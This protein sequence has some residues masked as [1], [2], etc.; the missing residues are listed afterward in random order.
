MKLFKSIWKDSNPL[1]HDFEEP[2]WLG[3]PH[4]ADQIDGDS[5]EGDE[6]GHADDQRVDVEG[7]EHQEQDDQDEQ[8][9]DAEAHLRNNDKI[10][11][12][13]VS[14]CIG[15]SFHQRMPFVCGGGAAKHNG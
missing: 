15:L 1:T 3:L 2:G 9:G 6:H 13:E 14:H 5:D 10:G 12:I 8:D 7:Q 11:S 4:D